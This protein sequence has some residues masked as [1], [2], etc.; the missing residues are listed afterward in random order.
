MVQFIQDEVNM[1]VS[2][3]DILSLNAKSMLIP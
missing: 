2:F 3:L 1:S